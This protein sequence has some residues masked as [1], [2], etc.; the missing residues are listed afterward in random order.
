MPNLNPTKLILAIFTPLVAAGAGWL[1]A[2]SAKYGVHLDPSGVN[3]LAVAGVTAGAAAMVKLI[4][5]VETAPTVEKI[6]HEITGDAAPLVAAVQ[7]AD[8]GAKPF[9]EDTIAQGE[10]ALEAKFQELVAQIP[11]PPV[12]APVVAAPAPAPA[13]AVT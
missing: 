4:H 12:A 8:P 1:T 11:Q 5:D 3:A 6:V 2:A 9:L 10:R 13:P 7:T